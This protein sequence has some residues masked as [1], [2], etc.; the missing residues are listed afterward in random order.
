MF[1]L[2][3]IQNIGKSLGKWKQEFDIIF[4]LLSDDKRT[5]FPDKF[6]RFLG[7]T[8]F[9]A[10]KYKSKSNPWDL[11]T[12]HYNYAKQ[13]PSTIKKY[14]TPELGWHLSDSN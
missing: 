12:A 13:I 8:I 5:Y 10:S 9:N 6:V 4:K 7:F 14:I 3:G 1:S 11:S 2:Y